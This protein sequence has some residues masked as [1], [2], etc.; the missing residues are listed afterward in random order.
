VPTTGFIYAFAGN[1][2]NG[3]SGDSGPATSAELSFPGYVCSDPFGNIYIADT[4][5]NRV[6]VVSSG[7]IS[8]YLG[9]GTTGVL[10]TPNG[11]CCDSSGNLY[12]ADSGNNRI[13]LV[14]Y[15]TK[16][17][18]TFATFTGQPTALCLDHAGNIYS[19]NSDYIAY[20]SPTASA[21]F[22]PF[23]GNGTPGYSGDSG[24][25]TSAQLGGP[26]LWGICSDASNNIYI[27]D[28]SNAAVRVVTGGIITTLKG[29]SDGLATPGD[30]VVDSSN[31]LYISDYSNL[32]VYKV[33]LT[34]HVLSTF[35]G[36]GISGSSGNNGPA[37]SAEFNGLI[38]LA[39]DSNNIYIADTGND[40]IRNIFIG[41]SPS[42][43]LVQ[44]INGHFQDMMGNPLANGTLLFELCHD[45]QEP[46]DPGQV[47]AGIK[48]TVQLDS[49]GNVPASPLSQLWA[50]SELTP[51]GSCYTLKA[52]DSTGAFVYGPQYIT[53]PD[54]SPYDLGNIVPIAPPGGCAGD[55]GGG[56]SIVLQTN[57]VNN[58]SQALLNLVNSGS[59]T[60][61]N[62]SGGNV[63]ATASGGGGGGV[64][65]SG[66]V[67][68]IPKWTGSTTLGDS[69]TLTDD[70]STLH[71]TGNMQLD[72]GI[73]QTPSVSGSP[74]DVTLF[75]GS[76]SAS[77]GANVV[78]DPGTGSTVNLTHNGRVSVR[79]QCAFYFGILNF[80]QLATPRGNPSNTFGAFV[81][82]SDAK[83]AADG[84]AWGSTAA[85]SGSGALLRYTGSNW[86]VIG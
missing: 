79:P 58:S 2:T 57:G 63:T 34:S 40:V 8:T 39:A 59:V 38:G 28:T 43:S 12:V 86:I 24:P 78:L 64:S 74:T 77:N 44:I 62:T 33:N 47:V 84:A 37:T 19:L 23:A 73:I 80:S 17:V 35:A 42:V 13:Q 27:A 30:V 51:S 50:N 52:Y 18:T 69:T 75:A 82:C 41:G 81:Y 76:S 1:G 3:F 20:Q 25:A 46:I 26:L 68:T 36:T 9:D 5:N 29:P 16:V 56:S 85:G 22:V 71:Y 49:G 14:N 83:G 72:G 6:R 55:T 67:N 7:T 65:G 53:I 61:T 10:N 45:E 11:I 66:T 4:N 54:S 21:A 15:S 32:F 70:G 48:K 60:F 31:N